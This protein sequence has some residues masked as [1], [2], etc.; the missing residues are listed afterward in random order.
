MTDRVLTTS[1]YNDTFE[2]W[3]DTELA[4]VAKVLAWA[5]REHPE[6][7]VGVVRHLPNVEK[8]E[9]CAEHGDMSAGL[10]GFRLDAYSCWAFTQIDWSLYPDAT[11]CDF[12]TVAV[13]PLGG[14]VT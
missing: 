13:V 4:D 7:L 9:W 3:E 8:V 10:Y 11:D 2:E 12:I 5:A 6:V 14:D 1:R